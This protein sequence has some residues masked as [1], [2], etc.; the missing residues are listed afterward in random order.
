[1]GNSISSSKTVRTEERIRYLSNK[2]NRDRRSTRQ[3]LPLTPTMPHRTGLEEDMA[4]NDKLL[5]QSLRVS[6]E[7]EGNENTR[8]RNQLERRIKEGRLVAVSIFLEIIN[9]K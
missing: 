8:P 4:T 7:V 2:V 9:R 1:M 5:I 3:H 6:N